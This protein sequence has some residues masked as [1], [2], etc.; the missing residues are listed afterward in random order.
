MN[1]ITIKGLNAMFSEITVTIDG[2]ITK[3]IVN[4]NGDFG[5]VDWIKYFKEDY[6]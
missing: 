6:K 1:K 2:R 5:L 4:N 3:H